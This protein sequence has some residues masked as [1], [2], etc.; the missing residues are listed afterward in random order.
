MTEF[1]KSSVIGAGMMERDCKCKGRNRCGAERWLA[2]KQKV[3]RP[4]KDT[5]AK[6][7][8]RIYNRTK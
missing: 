3:E 7:T 5:R 6:I 1:Q 8:K 2:K 4:Y